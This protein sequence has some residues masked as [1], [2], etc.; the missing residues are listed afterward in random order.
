MKQITDISHNNTFEQ[1]AQNILTVDNSMQSFAIKA[2]NQT[3]TLRNWIIGGYIIEYEQNGSD[4]AKYGDNLLKSLEKRIGVKGLNV[5]LFQFSRLF[6]NNYPHICTMFSTNYA[7]VSHNLPLSK[8]YATVLHSLPQLYYLTIKEQNEISEQFKTPAEKLVSTLSFSHIRELLTI[9]DP[10]IRF[11]YETECIRGTWSVRELR[12]QIATNLHIR[13]GLS[14]DR[15]KA[16]QFTDSKAERQSVSLQI[17]DPYTF[18]FL[19]LKAKSH[20][21]VFISVH[22][23]ELF[24]GAGLF[25]GFPLA[26]QKHTDRSLALAEDRVVDSAPDGKSHFHRCNPFF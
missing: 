25:K 22:H 9:D 10:L 8:I 4:R 16:M 2:V 20:A 5:T 15:M 18:E 21:E 24:E 7:T 14:A 1:L 23:K 11:F 13:I 12:R 26:L 6:Y 17:R 3:A 19:G